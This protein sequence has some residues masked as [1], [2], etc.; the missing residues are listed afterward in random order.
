M[1][2]QEAFPFRSLVIGTGSLR[3]IGKNL[4][5]AQEAARLSGHLKKKGAGRS[6]DLESSLRS[7][8]RLPET[9]LRVIAREALLNVSVISMATLPPRASSS[10]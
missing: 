4:L 10:L 5:V 1:G 6:S 2:F 9:L 3:P 7:F 8:K